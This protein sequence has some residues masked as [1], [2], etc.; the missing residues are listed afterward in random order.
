MK[1]PATGA[2]PAG[3]ADEA[4]AAVAVRQ[5]FETIDNQVGSIEIYYLKAFP[6]A[7]ERKSP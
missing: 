3:A 1:M 6:L 2:R 5:L 7:F 4:G